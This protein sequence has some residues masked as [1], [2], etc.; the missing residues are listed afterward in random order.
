MK[1]MLDEIE[2]KDLIEVQNTFKAELSLHEFLRQGWRYI[3]G[4]KTFTDGWHIA[5][6]AEHLEAVANRQ[7]KNLIINIPP[8]CCKSN[9]VS[10]AF[11]AWVWLHQPNEQFLYASHALSLSFSAS[12]KCRELIMSP[13]YQRNWGN[14]YQLLK[15]QNT[16]S[17]FDNTKKGFRIASSSG[18]SVT[19]EGGSILVGDDI[20][21]A[22]EG[23]ESAVIREGKIDWWTQ[24][25]S[26]RLNNKKNDCKIVIQQRIHERDITGYVMDHSEE[27]E[28]TKLILPMRYAERRCAV[29]VVL[30]S[31]YPNVWQD[32]RMKERDLLWPERFNE[33]AV[34]EMEEELGAYGTAAQLEQLPSPAIGGILKKDSFQW[35]KHTEPPDIVF[36]VQ[37]WDTAFSEAKTSAYSACTTWG[38]FYD[39]NDIENVI[40]LSVWRGRV[41]YVELRE[42]AKRLYFDYRDTAKERN[43]KYTGRP[44]DLFLIEA[45]ASGD[46]LIRDL[47]VAG[48]SAIPVVP[49]PKSDKIKRV[50]FVSPLIDGGRVWVPARGPKFDTLL[51]F[52]DEFVELAACFPNLE[53]N[54]VIDTMSQA[55]M[56]LKTGMFLYNPKDE[57]PI[58]PLPVDKKVY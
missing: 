37:S 24:V 5:A 40:L 44:I 42:R 52:A 56:K 38:V 27:D 14:R 13:W 6:I 25:W 34:A 19:G 53:S 30:P 9:L 50:G 46:P 54:D 48:I 12:R 49:P 7:I 41:E 43:S 32:P 55:L 20:N 1:E 57:R 51:P 8:R 11:P 39:H 29:T 36:V 31:S 47:R 26:T 3:E 10:V 28:W 33:R 45:K 58:N 22:E 17:R 2:L 35:W 4:D 18:S 21:G 23:G 16:K 15:D